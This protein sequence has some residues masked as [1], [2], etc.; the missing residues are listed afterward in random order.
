MNAFKSVLLVLAGCVSVSSYA[1]AK[2][3]VPAP[4][5][6]M[7]QFGAEVVES[8]PS[9]KAAG[10]TGWVVRKGA[11]VRFFYTPPDG[12]FLIAGQLFDK[13]GKNLSADDFKRAEAVAVKTVGA[14]PPMA[15]VAAQPQA[16]LPGGMPSSPQDAAAQQRL[17][18]YLKQL[19]VV[20]SGASGVAGAP[21][22]KPQD[23][24][25]AGASGSMTGIEQLYKMADS[26]TWIQ[27]GSGPRI[28]YVIFDPN[29]GYCH[30]F[31]SLAKSIDRSVTQ[32]R[33][34]PVVAVSQESPEHN[35]AILSARDRL[36]VLR[37]TMDGRPQKAPMTPEIKAKLV[38]NYQIMRASG[39]SGVPTFIWKEAGGRVMVSQGTPEEATLKRLFSFKR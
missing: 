21:L 12:K 8:F 6:K 26:S 9:A 23:A 1:F 10:Y 24:P 14:Q 5:Q 27:D 36:A 38:A 18:D 31:Y 25:Q 33:W 37:S 35:A 29:C 2:T 39:S 17:Q 16:G 20:R 3:S 34:I 30:A 15:P 19:E 32:I 22:A 4:I 13:D 11:S 7:Q 28:V